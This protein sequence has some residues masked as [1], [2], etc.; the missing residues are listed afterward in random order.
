MWGWINVLE[1]ASGITSAGG[2]LY[3]AFTISG[4]CEETKGKC[5]KMSRNNSQKLDAI[6]FY[7]SCIVFKMSFVWKIYIIH[8]G[9]V[10]DILNS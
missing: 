8:W 6:L 7:N 9:I 2:F 3:W 10:T 1:I 4:T 5:E